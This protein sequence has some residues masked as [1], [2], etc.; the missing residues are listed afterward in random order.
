MTYYYYF[1]TYYVFVSE[2][3]AHLF[4]IEKYLLD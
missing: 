2:M 3:R 1:M 4:P